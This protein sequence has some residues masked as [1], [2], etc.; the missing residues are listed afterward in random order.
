MYHDVSAANLGR[1]IQQMA[2]L[3]QL[4]KPISA[5]SIGTLQKGRHHVAV[6]FDDGFA[7]T[8]EQVLPVLTN[9]NIP[10]TFFIPT[11]QL[12]KEAAWITAGERR[13]L[14]GPIL[15]A[16]NLKRL[17]MQ[18]G[19]TIGSHGAQHLR[20]T[21]ITDDEA[22]KELSE[23]KR[24]LEN[25]TGKELKMLAFPYGAYS[26]RHIAIAQKI[27]FHYI[28]T[29]NPIIVSE[30]S[31]KFVIARVAVKPT[32]CLIEFKLKVLGAYRWHPHVS[33]LKKI[34]WHQHEQ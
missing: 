25:L 26:D 7:D 9:K 31:E 23:S 12:G 17:A 24:Q 20:L 15:M 33:R 27:G 32:D 19:V 8:I 4:A 14:A 1:F 5:D 34:L 21:E 29:V 28:F 30:A 3:P 22:W 18:R 16:E 6:T 2:I 11:A 13:K 10:A